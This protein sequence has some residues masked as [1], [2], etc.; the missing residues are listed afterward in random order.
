MS[1][2]SEAFRDAIAEAAGDGI[3]PEE[4]FGVIEDWHPAYDGEKQPPSIRL[5]L[6]A[7]EVDT[8]L[9]Q[10]PVGSDNEAFNRVQDAASLLTRVRDAAL[11]MAGDSIA[12]A[13][14]E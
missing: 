5:K 2:N 8:F 12:E 6:M 4:L 1:W 13:Q 14:D 7:D 11:E 9:S 3:S 10:E